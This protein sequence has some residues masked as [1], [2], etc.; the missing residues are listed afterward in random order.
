LVDLHVCPDYK[1][2][3]C[4]KSERRLLGHS[5]ENAVAAW[6]ATHGFP[7]PVHGPDVVG[8][9]ASVLPIVSPSDAVTPTTSTTPSAPRTPSPPRA[10]TA[11]IRSSRP[12]RSCTASSRSSPR[13]RR[14]RCRSRSA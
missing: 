7:W 6:N 3:R 12:G 1:T 2:A 14:C 13:R 5:R 10:R 9:F 4:D 8:S 11:Y